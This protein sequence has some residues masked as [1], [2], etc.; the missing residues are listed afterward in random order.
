MRDGHRPL[1]RR[2]WSAIEKASVTWAEKFR[3]SF[4]RP[5]ASLDDFPIDVSFSILS[6]RGGAEVRHLPRSFGG[7]VP[8]E[9]FRP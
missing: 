1:Y 8:T 6:V 4:F 2:F 5:L 7:G 9:G 3:P